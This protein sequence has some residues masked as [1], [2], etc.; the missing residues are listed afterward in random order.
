MLSAYNLV[1]AFHNIFYISSFQYHI[2]LEKIWLKFTI[3]ILLCLV[4]DT[5]GNLLLFIELPKLNQIMNG[6]TITKLGFL[7]KALTLFIIVIK[8]MEYIDTPT[9]VDNKFVIILTIL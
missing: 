4:I 7:F 1:L 6:K 2:N 8:I 3:A 5:L 9:Y